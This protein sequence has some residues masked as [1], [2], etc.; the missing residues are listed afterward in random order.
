MVM[1]IAIDPC[2]NDVYVGGN[3]HAAKNFDNTS[4]NPSPSTFSKTSIAVWNGYWRKVG[5]YLV[6]YT[7]N[8][9]A[10]TSASHV[11]SGDVNSLYYYNNKIY[12]AAQ[13]VTADGYMPAGNS[14]YLPANPGVTFTNVAVWNIS[15]QL[16]EPFGSPTQNG[17]NGTVNAIQIDIINRYVYVCGAFTTVSDSANLNKSAKGIAYYNLNTQR[18]AELGS[19]ANNGVN[20]TCNTITLDNRNNRLY[21]GGTYT[22]S[23]DVDGNKN[24]NNRHMD[25]ESIKT[26]IKYL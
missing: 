10:Y 8:Q 14:L 5:I 20:G 2:N 12:A 23:T 6:N 16:W 7:L 17:C 11:V 26:L 25:T 1:L 13:S 18:W 4:S 3:F 9:Y 19:G 21:V 24:T 15:S 22:I